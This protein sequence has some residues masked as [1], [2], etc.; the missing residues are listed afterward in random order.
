MAREWERLVRKREAR[1]GK[2]REVIVCTVRIVCV[3]GRRFI[4]S[5]VA[6]QNS[7]R[8]LCKLSAVEC[9]AH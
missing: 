9:K 7:I 8:V 1:E 5:I 6:R 3:V 4:A 2:T